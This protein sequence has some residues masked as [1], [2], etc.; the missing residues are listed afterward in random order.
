MAV[1]KFT[2]KV[3]HQVDFFIYLFFW[4]KGEQPVF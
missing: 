3:Y 4:V 2:K 1:G